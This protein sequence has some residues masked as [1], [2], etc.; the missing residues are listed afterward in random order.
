MHRGA[1]HGNRS[2]ADTLDWSRLGYHPSVLPPRHGSADADS[3]GTTRPYCHLG[4]AVRTPIRT[5]SPIAASGRG[6]RDGQAEGALCS[7]VAVDHDVVRLPGGH[8][9]RQARG[10]G[11]AGRIGAG[12]VV[13]PGG[14]LGPARAASAPQVEDGVG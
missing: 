9:R 8:R 13:A 10:A 14:D 4:T 6:W 1:P 11:E 5:L 2:A 3:H 12:V 7:V